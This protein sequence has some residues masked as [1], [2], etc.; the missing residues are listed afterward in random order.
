VANAVLLTLSSVG[1]RFAPRRSN[2]IQFGLDLSDPREL[3][4]QTAG[5]VFNRADKG[6]EL[7]ARDPIAALGP[8]VDSQNPRPGRW[9]ARL[10]I[11]R[12][13]RGCRRE[14]SLFIEVLSPKPPI[15]R[16]FAR[17]GNGYSTDQ[18]TKPGAGSDFS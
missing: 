6:D 11:T 15:S 2:V 18:P 3:Q 7:A 14:S 5:A 8:F 16:S 17:F 9:I 1:F 4:L 12:A 13:I 10:Y